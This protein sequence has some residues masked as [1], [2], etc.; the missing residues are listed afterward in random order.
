MFGFLKKIV[1]DVWCDC[2]FISNVNPMHVSQSFYSDYL[3]GL[4]IVPPW[5]ENPGWFFE[6]PPGGWSLISSW[7]SLIPCVCSIEEAKRR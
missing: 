4:H 2:F 3:I 5:I 1:A 6:C 7:P